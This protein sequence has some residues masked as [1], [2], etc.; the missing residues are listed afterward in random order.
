MVGPLGGGIRAA[1]ASVS[2]KPSTVSINKQ[3]DIQKVAHLRLLKDDPA[4]I[5]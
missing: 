5:N 2:V 4:K 3:S 1:L